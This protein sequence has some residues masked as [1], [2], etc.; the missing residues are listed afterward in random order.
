M[1]HARPVVEA[2]EERQRGQPHQVV[3]AVLVARQQHQVVR[4]VARAVGAG[5]AR[6]IRLHAENR[7]DPGLARLLVELDGAEQRTVISERQRRHAQ[8]SRPRDHAADRAGAVEQRVVAV[9]VEVDEVGVFHGASCAAALSSARGAPARADQ[10]RCPANLSQS[11]RS[12]GAG[13]RPC[14]PRSRRHAM[15][16]ARRR[17]A[18]LPAQLAIHRVPLAR[19]P[20]AIHHDRTGARVHPAAFLRQPR[21]ERPARI[22][23]RAAARA[24]RLEQARCAAPRGPR[25][26]RTV[27][28]APGARST[29]A[30][31]IRRRCAT[32]SSISPAPRSQAT[33]CPR[34]RVRRR[35][36]QIPVAVPPRVEPELAIRMRDRHGRAQADW[37]AQREPVGAEVERAPHRNQVPDRRHARA[38]RRGASPS[39]IPDQSA[40]PRP[41]ASRIRARAPP[42]ARCWPALF[43]CWTSSVSSGGGG[44]SNSATNDRSAVMPGQIARS[45]S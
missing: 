1:V 25:R 31:S 11:Y 38:S 30:A 33:G 7:L 8:F 43:S 23:R 29:T 19:T 42:P 20:A 26:T 34:A 10:A 37:L 35:V 17:R 5:A 44:E 45:G 16:S 14:P 36:E 13:F 4:G 40:I 2:L 27:R 32:A 28:G 6:D 18:R 9:I 15:R 3:E 41:S 24:R 39:R 21:L 12:P 22:G